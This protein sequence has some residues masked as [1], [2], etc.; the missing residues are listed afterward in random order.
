MS[1]WQTAHSDLKALVA[2]EI[3]AMTDYRLRIMT[4]PT[5]V[6][7]STVGFFCLVCW[8]S[9]DLFVCFYFG[10]VWVGVFL[11]CFWYH[12]H[13]Q[14]HSLAYVWEMT[15]AICNGPYGWL[16]LWR[17]GSECLI[18]IS[19]I[20]WMKAQILSRPQLLYE[21]GLFVVSLSYSC[22]LNLA[23]MLQEHC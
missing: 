15:D 18:Y 3:F 7:C 10:L 13:Q 14:F 12:L 19:S 11:M 16:R 9:F 6:P 8:L 23:L 21:E 22:T 2:I 4:F 20:W 1:I 5:T 17:A